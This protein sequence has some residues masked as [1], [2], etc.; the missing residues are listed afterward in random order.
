MQVFDGVKDLREIVD[1]DLLL[2]VHQ[3][4]VKVDFL[5]DSEHVTKWTMLQ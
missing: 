3:L 5:H 4:K 2:A 1:N